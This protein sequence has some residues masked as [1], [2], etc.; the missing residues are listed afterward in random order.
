M[1]GAT[2]DGM[3]IFHT[4]RRTNKGSAGRTRPQTGTG[5]EKKRN[6]SSHADMA[7]FIPELKTFHGGEAAQRERCCTTGGYFDHSYFSFSADAMR[8]VGVV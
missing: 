1:G 4:G 7:T 2:N 8:L 3:L 6:H 5:R